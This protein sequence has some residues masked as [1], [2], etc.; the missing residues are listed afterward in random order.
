VNPNDKFS[1]LSTLLDGFALIWS[2][3]GEALALRK[4][5]NIDT[6]DETAQAAQR[7]GFEICYLDLPEK[8]SGFAEIIDGTRFIAL[9]GTSPN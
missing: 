4:D 8:V 3:A 5:L 9:T 1:A 7:A 6:L 2:P